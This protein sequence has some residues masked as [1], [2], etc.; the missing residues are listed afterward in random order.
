MCSWSF[1]WGLNSLNLNLAKNWPCCCRK[2]R[3][4]E[5]WKINYK[6]YKRR[7]TIYYTLKSCKFQMRFCYTLIWKYSILFCGIRFCALCWLKWYIEHRFLTNN[8]RYNYFLRYWVLKMGVT[9]ILAITVRQN[10]LLSIR[11]Y[12]HVTSAW[13]G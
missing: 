4:R 2:G 1:L 9:F 11:Y 7:R 12:P 8:Y 6:L 10:F 3:K 5:M 13:K